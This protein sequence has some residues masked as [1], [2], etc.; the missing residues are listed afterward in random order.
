MY[1]LAAANFSSSSINT[2][3]LPSGLPCASPSPSTTISGTTASWFWWCC[4]R[5]ARMRSNFASMASILAAP[6]PPSAPSR[7][8]S[9]V[10]SG[11]DVVRRSPI[12]GP[13]TA[14]APSTPPTPPKRDV[15]FVRRDIA[16]AILPMDMLVGGGG[17]SPASPNAAAAFAAAAIAAFF[18]LTTR[19]GAVSWS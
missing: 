14:A 19:G 7:P 16:E 17:A 9:V 10:E 8:S 1:G 11:E 2:L 18:S 13:C 15:L 3:W 5:A 6:A 4:W 12:P